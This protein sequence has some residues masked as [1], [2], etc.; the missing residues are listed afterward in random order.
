[1]PVAI[2]NL[3]IGHFLNS[4]AFIVLGALQGLDFLDDLGQLHHRELVDLEP[5]V[6]LPLPI[7]LKEAGLVHELGAVHR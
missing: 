6:V 4:I 7:I 5:E 3:G 2:V 1:M